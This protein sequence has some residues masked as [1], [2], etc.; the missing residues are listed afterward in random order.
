MR[1]TA[2][3]NVGLGRMDSDATD[4]IGVGLKHVHPLQGVVIKH[5]DLH[6]ILHKEGKMFTTQQKIL[7]HT[8]SN[9]LR[10]TSSL[11]GSCKTHG[12]QD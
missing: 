12:T 7:K 10:F 5:T 4:V 8:K 2:G 11:L 6:V 3:E 9:H 1:T